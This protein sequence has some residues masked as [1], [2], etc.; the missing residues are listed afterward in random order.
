MHTL[1]SDFTNKKVYLDIDSTPKIVVMKNIL[2][3]LVAL[4]IGF[5]SFS[6]DFKLH[7]SGL[8]SSEFSSNLDI[9]KAN[10]TQAQS[11]IYTIERKADSNSQNLLD[12]SE[13]KKMFSNAF[14]A[15]IESN[16]N[17]SVT[18]LVNVYISDY[19]KKGRK[20]QFTVHFES[21]LEQH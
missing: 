10:L 7:I 2:F 19:S 3:L 18:K 9:K 14:L 4:F 20:E 8:N 17:R 5:T 11:G 12:A 16:G 15:V 21:A 6:Q 13:N 1:E